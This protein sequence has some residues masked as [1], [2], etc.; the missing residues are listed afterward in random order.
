MKNVNI[1]LFLQHTVDFVY[2]FYGDGLIDVSD[3]IQSKI[4]AYTTG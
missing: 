4:Q 2:V 1:I 3:W